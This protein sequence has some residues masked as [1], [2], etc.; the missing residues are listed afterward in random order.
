MAHL[1]YILPK[2]TEID[3]RH[4]VVKATGQ[5]SYPWQVPVDPKG[6][7]GRQYYVGVTVHIPPSLEGGIKG[8]SGLAGGE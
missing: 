1:D 4:L 8:C 7:I 2:T 6:F 3:P 5:N